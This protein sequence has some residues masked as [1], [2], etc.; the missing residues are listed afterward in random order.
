M[1]RKL[2]SVYETDRLHFTSKAIP[3]HSNLHNEQGWLSLNTCK[4][5]MDW[6]GTASG[7]MDFPRNNGNANTEKYAVKRNAFNTHAHCMYMAIHGSITLACISTMS[8]TRGHRGPLE[9]YWIWCFMS[10]GSELLECQKR[11]F[12]FVDAPRNNGRTF[13][14]IRGLQPNVCFGTRKDTL[15]ITQAHSQRH[16]NIYNSACFTYR[17]CLYNRSISD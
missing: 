8:F 16:G 5:T 3:K 11:G 4:N 7:L 2:V 17:S 9:D 12:L 14:P 15:W 13:A 1:N 10:F 6:A